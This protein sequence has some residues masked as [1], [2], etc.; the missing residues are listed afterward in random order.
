MVPS[1]GVVLWIQHFDHFGYASQSDTPLPLSLERAH[2]V[3]GAWAGEGTVLWRGFRS[4]GL[5]ST[6]G[7][8]FGPDASDVD[9]AVVA[10]IIASIKP[11]MDP[12]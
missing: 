9:R 3:Q 6:F 7:V 10:G 4:G 8:W 5:G 12:R 11:F 2:G 1:D